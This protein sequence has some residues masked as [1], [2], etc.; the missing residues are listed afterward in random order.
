MLGRRVE[1]KTSRQHYFGQVVGHIFGKGSSLGKYD[2]RITT[3][4][5]GNK[6]TG[7]VGRFSTL[8]C[9]TY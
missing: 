6:K 9:S 3:V 5:Q 1:V 2:V 8:D 7:Q 4:I